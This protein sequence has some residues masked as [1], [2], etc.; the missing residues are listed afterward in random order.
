GR[1]LIASF[2]VANEF[3]N[4][5]L[6]GVAKIISIPPPLTLN[7]NPDNNSLYDIDL[8]ELILKKIPVAYDPQSKVGYSFEEFEKLR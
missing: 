7:T 4:A 1:R 2:S 3:W 8:T 6:A 5:T